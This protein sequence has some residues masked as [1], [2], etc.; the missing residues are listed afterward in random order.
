MVH[1][2]LTLTA[3]GEMFTTKTK[4]RKLLLASMAAFHTAAVVYHWVFEENDGTNRDSR[5]ASSGTIRTSA[6]STEAFVYRPDG[7]Y[8]RSGGTAVRSPRE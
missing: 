6:K 4:T 5:G 1:L 8:F 7:I 2:G 3:V